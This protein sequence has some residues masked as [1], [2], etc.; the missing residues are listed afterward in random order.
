MNTTDTQVNLVASSDSNAY[1]IYF[2]PA[3]NYE[4]LLRTGATLAGIVTGVE[5]NWFYIKLGKRT[6]QF[7]YWD[8]EEAW[9]LYD[10]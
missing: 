7:Y 3:H 5:P 9:E 6:R 2:T 4:L 10:D 8:I 1:Y